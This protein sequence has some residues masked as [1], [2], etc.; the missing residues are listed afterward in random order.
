MNFSIEK[1]SNKFKIFSSLIPG[2]DKL[3]LEDKQ[4]YPAPHV[5]LVNACV[6]LRSWWDDC[7]GD[8]DWLVDRHSSESL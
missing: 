6:T 2:S 5:P 3:L 1:T 8:V 7:V 4:L